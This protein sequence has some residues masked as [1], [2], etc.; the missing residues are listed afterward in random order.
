MT[1]SKEK[2]NKI[3]FLGKY[4]PKDTEWDRKLEKILKE[5]IYQEEKKKNK[6][7]QGYFGE[8]YSWDFETNLWLNR[9]KQAVSVISA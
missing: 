8:G 5:K 6:N 4:H 9:K 2:E 1:N 7:N 3:D